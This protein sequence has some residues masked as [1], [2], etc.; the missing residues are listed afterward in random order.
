METTANPTP[1]A[2]AIPAA[3]APAPAVTA[4]AAGPKLYE[5]TQ[6]TLFNAAELRRLTADYETIRRSCAV[7]LAVLFRTEFELNLTSLNT[8][9]FRQFTGEMPQPTHLTLFKVETLRGVGVLE[10]SPS[11]ALSLLDRLMGGPGAANIPV[12]ELTEIEIALLGQITHLLTEAW[13]AHW[14]I[15]RELKSSLIGNENDPR[16]LQT[17]PPDS[18]M[19]VAAFDARIGDASGKIRIALPFSTVEPILQV[20]RAEL[21]PPVEAP[22]PT[23]TPTK[24]AAWNPALDHVAIPVT[25]ELPGPQITARELQQLKVGDVLHISADAA[26]LVQVK[27][28]GV[29]R[30]NARLGTRDQHWAVEVLNALAS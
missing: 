30:F 4:A 14:E 22:L 5:L 25:A 11:L 8:P 28:G 18:A 16:F 24:S 17:S 7:R 12:R 21:K 29:P 19:L 23:A 27:L 20:I 2:A 26:S 10:L 3:P 13:C 1:P 9:T 15:G 6:R